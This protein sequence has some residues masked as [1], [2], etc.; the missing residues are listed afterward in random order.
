M[1][2]VAVLSQPVRDVKPEVLRP[3]MLRPRRAKRL[4]VGL[5][6]AQPPGPRGPHHR[7]PHPGVHR[8]ALAC[9]CLVRENQEYRDFVL[10]RF[11]DIPEMMDDSSR[12]G[13][14]YRWNT[15]V[16]IRIVPDA[17]LSRAQQEVVEMDYG[18]EAGALEVTTRGRLVPYALKLLHIDPTDKLSEPM[19]QQIIVENRAELLP[20]LFG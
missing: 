5:R 17:R 14:R 1:A 3:I 7:A 13:R 9:T 6:I 15:R 11:R 19:A 8:A 10:S 18:M 20:W 12:C 2:N 4:D 16:T